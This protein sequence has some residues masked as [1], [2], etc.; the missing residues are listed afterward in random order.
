M[1]ENELIVSSINIYE[2]GSRVYQTATEFYDWDYIA[3]VPDDFPKEPDQYEFGNHTY[4][5]EH[6]SEWISKLQRNS[7]EALECLSLSPKF[8]VKKT[9]SYP[10]TFNPDGAHAAISERASIAWVKGKKK[11]TIEKDFD[12]R[13]GKKSIW[14][15]LRL[16]LFGCQLAQGGIIWDYTIANKYYNDIVI[17]KHGET[18]QEEWEYL[19]KTYHTLNNNLHSQM[20]A[21]FEK[22]KTGEYIPIYSIRP[23]KKYYEVMKNV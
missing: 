14:H 15:S 18:G 3:V 21:E 9:K 13:G 6:E 1:T 22:V 16:Y 17:T 20:K 7:V 8:I 11:L 5:I 23:S 19:K 10:F 4:N 2:W 12:W